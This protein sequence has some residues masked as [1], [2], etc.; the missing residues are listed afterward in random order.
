MG[1]LFL[2]GSLFAIT[3]AATVT[4][5][6]DYAPSDPIARSEATQTLW[7]CRHCNRDFMLSADEVAKLGRRGPDR[8][9]GL[10]CPGCRS[11]ELYLARSCSRCE[12]VYLGPEVPGVDGKCPT[13][14]G[15]RTSPDPGRKAPSSP[16]GLKDHRKQKEAARHPVKVI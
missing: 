2:A 3:L 15:D 4:L 6:S 14:H 12:T 11:F 5:Q 13:C 7:M 1:K 9:T 10:R 16:E 8:F